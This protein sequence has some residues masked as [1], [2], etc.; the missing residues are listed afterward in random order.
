ETRLNVTLMEMLRQHFRKE[1][2]GLDPL[3]EDSHGVDVGRVFQIFRDAVCNLPGWEVKTD[4]WIGQFSFT[5]F[6][7]WKDLADRLSDLSKNR[8]VKHLVE[9]AGSQYPNP[10]DDIRPVG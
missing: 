6:L 2:P 5:K 7:L 1:L 9:E 3:P 8:I 4:I 10:P